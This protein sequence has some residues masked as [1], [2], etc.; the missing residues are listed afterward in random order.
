VKKILSLIILLSISVYTYT[1]KVSDAKIE[2]NNIDIKNLTKE[3]QEFDNQTLELEAKTLTEKEPEDKTL[4]KKIEVF[5]QDTQDLQKDE[6]LIESCSKENTEELTTK[7]KK[8]YSKKELR[9]MKKKEVRERK[10]KAAEKR[11]KSNKEA[12]TF[13]KV[14]LGTM[15]TIIVGGLTWF[16]IFAYG[17][18]TF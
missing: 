10:K 6:K 18:L 3:S 14:M 11:R 15:G 12:T 16:G 2:T 1:K 5:E 13:T 4:E 9:K 17:M 7:T 8:V